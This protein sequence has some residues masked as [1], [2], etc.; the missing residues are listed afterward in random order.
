MKISSFGFFGWLIVILW[1][2]LVIALIAGL[3]TLLAKPFFKDG[4]WK[5]VMM[6]LCN[7][8]RKVRSAKMGKIGLRK[9][10]RVKD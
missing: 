4:L 8:A 10:K 5:T 3:I 2:L 7:A 9:N 1:W 6:T